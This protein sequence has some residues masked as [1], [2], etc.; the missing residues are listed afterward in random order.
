MDP[1]VRLRRSTHMTAETRAFAADQDASPFLASPRIVP[2]TLAQRSHIGRDLPD[3]ALRHV[4]T[5]HFGIGQ[6]VPDHTVQGE[7]SSAAWQRRCCQVRA[8]ASVAFGPMTTGAPAGIE[9]LTLLDIRDA[10]IRI[11][12]LRRKVEER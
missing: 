1:R 6:S 7:V 9:F 2:S 3:L 5:G 11:L 8:L 4:V 12:I 10:G